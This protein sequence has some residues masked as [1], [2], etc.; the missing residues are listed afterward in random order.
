[1]PV[2]TPNATIPR[3][4]CTILTCDPTTTP[5]TI[6]AQL[7]GADA[8]SV[9][10]IGVP[11]AF[12]WPEV[13]ETWVV[14][15]ENGAWYLDGRAL[16]SSDV[17]PISILEAGQMRLDGNQI[18]DANGN[19]LVAVPSPG[20]AGQILK[21]DPATGAP[22]WVPW[23]I[24]RGTIGAVFAGSTEVDATVTHGLGGTPASAI[25][26]GSSPDIMISTTSK[27]GTTFIVRFFSRTGSPLTATYAADWVAV[28]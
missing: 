28:L 5:P 23:G 13:G 1:M 11:G 7:K 3:Y 10:I 16:D 18:F 8:R 6:E 12:R 21:I 24:A 20:T 22:Q 27:T 19:Q 15:Q 2:G 26:T 25:A 17:L 4:T 14:R 9:S